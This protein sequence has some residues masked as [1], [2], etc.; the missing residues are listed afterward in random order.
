MC[1][2]TGPE[3][4]SGAAGRHYSIEQPGLSRRALITGAL[5]AA[6]ALVLIGSSSFT[7]APAARAVSRPEIIPC[8]TW[9]ASPP[10]GSIS[11]SSTPQ[12]VVVHHMASSNGTGTDLNAAYAIARQVQGWH[13]DNG[14][15]DTG[16]HFSV[17]RGGYILEGR[18][19]TIEGLNSGT[20]F[21]IGSHV[22]G[23]NSTCLGI[24]TEG[25]FSTVQPTSAQWDSL[26]SLIAYLCSTYGISVGNIRGHRDFNSTLCPGDAFY[27]RLQ[28]LRN[29]VAARLDGDDG[30]GGEEPPPSTGEPWPVLQQGA[31]GY[32]VTALQ[33]LLRHHGRTL[34]IDGSFG[35]ETLSQ[36]RGFQE[37]QG[38]AVDGSVGPITWRALTPTLT[39]GAVSVAVAA[40]QGLLTNHGHGIA[41]D[42][43]FGP[44]TANAVRSFQ[45][46]NG[47]AVDG[48]VGP[49]TWSHLLRA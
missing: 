31:E 48:S 9:G 43:H 30:G 19:R 49:V 21:P 2:Q 46:A 14:W 3:E 32:R 27:P 4:E 29:A 39:E 12:Y 11:M 18:H 44:A 40:L 5:G 6:G 38:L 28:E 42:E 20:T 1:Q 10:R 37:A 8:A 35:P 7:A 16:Q 22:G 24:E 13:F 41:V 15:T 25:N 34:S 17:S 26:V 47:L 33:R 45:S 23:N 36:V